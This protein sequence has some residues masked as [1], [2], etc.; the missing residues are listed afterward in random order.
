M[1]MDRTIVYLHDGRAWIAELK[2]DRAQVS[3]LVAWLSAHPGRGALRSLALEPLSPPE[4]RAHA[5]GSG[6]IRGGLTS[7]LGRLLGRRAPLDPH[8]DDRAG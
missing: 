7:V 5:W 2:D 1:N 3:S 4:P 8:P 6:R